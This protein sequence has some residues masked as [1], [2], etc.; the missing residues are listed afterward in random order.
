MD[1]QCSDPTVPNWLHESARRIKGDTARL[2]PCRSAYLGD[3][4]RME[5]DT[6]SSPLPKGDTSCIEGVGW[7][8]ASTG[9]G[10]RVEHR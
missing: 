4:G 5:G 9:P 8:R 3:R 10:E 7:A 1:V 6:L 2:E